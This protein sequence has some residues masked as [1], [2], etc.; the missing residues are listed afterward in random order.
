MT[1]NTEKHDTFALAGEINAL[2]QRSEAANEDLRLE[3]ARK[4]VEAEK[5]VG[6]DG[7]DDWVKAHLDLTPAYVGTMLQIGKA[8]DPKA[9][10]DEERE[11]TRGR[12]A[13]HRE[14]LRNKSESGDGN[15]D[16][17]IEIKLPE[18]LSE[19]ST[20][21]EVL[22]KLEFQ[23]RKGRWVVCIKKP[24]PAPEMADAA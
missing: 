6:V 10:L 4:L 9:A 8:A 23:R 5:A 2:F 15:S 1:D 11:K 22:A 12:V 7:W 19:C 17:H 20:Q 18:L 21:A 24:A 14:M 3:L 16:T 13:K